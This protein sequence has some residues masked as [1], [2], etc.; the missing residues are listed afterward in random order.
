MLTE[1]YFASISGP[2]ITNNTAIAKDVGIYEHVLHPSHSTANT[3][4]KTSAPANALAV[5]DTHVFSAQDGKSTV[6]IYSREKG[7]QE[8]TVTFQEK[9]KSLVLLGDVLLLG[10]DQGRI[11]VWEVR[12][13][14]FLNS[15]K[16]TDL[17]L[18][19]H[20]QASHHSCM[21]CP[22]DQLPCCHSLSLAY[23]F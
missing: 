20:R 22:G 17:D 23:R 4:K 18:D 3:F 7:N 2:P 13:E 14:Q 8:A 12:H 21:P 19:L 6:H 15:G 5:S 10:T 16:N 11:I 1:R 9:I